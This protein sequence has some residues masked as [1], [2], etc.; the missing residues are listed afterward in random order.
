MNSV[1][2][3]IIQIVVLVGG[4]IVGNKVIFGVVEV[5]MDAVVGAVAICIIGD[6]AGGNKPY[7]GVNRV[8]ATR[9]GLHLRPAEETV[10]DSLEWFAEC[11]PRGDFQWTNL[12]S[13]KEADLLAAWTHHTS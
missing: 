3:R 12:S 10:A 13:A 6:A 4:L 1:P 11:F 2:L 5:R 8:K 7:L 9:A